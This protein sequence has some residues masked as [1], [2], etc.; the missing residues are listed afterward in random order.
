MLSNILSTV[1]R[2]TSP[3]TATQ[4]TLTAKK[5]MTSNSLALAAN[6]ILTANKPL[7]AQLTHA[8]TMRRAPHAQTRLDKVL[9][10]PAPN[11]QETDQS[12]DLKKPQTRTLSQ[13]TFTQATQQLKT[14]DSKSPHPLYAVP[15]IQVNNKH[16]PVDSPRLFNLKMQISPFKKALDT[17]QA[18]ALTGFDSSGLTVD[19]LAEKKRTSILEKLNSIFNTLS[20]PEEKSELLNILEYQLLGPQAEIGSGKTI[21]PECIAQLH[22]DCHQI[23][24]SHGMSFSD[25]DALISALQSQRG[26]G[27]NAQIKQCADAAAHSPWP[28]EPKNKDVHYEDF[29]VRST[30]G[31]SI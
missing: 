17:V 1:F 21:T 26:D 28:A 25:L 27:G 15:S 7:A 20:T 12:K 16:M 19:I 24:A 14:P 31:R 3:T 29:E 30:R 6:P 22:Y 23:L 5:L 13:T 10:Q 11:T 8:I 4:T 9:T 18:L 2:K